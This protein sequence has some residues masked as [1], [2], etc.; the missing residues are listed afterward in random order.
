MRNGAKKL[1]IQKY[2]IQ[3]Q[4][5]YADFSH[6]KLERG[7]EL[8][9][10]RYLKIFGITIAIQIMGIALGLLLAFTPEQDYRAFLILIVIGYVA[11][12]SMDIYLSV[13][14]DAIWYK[15]LIYIFLMPTNYTPVVLPW[16][17]VYIFAKFFEMLPHNLG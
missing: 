8:I 14:S 16:I 9:M 5:K 2:H 15:K 1:C 4:R 11:S 7:F 10:K 3:N 12:L 6:K 17:A 13:K